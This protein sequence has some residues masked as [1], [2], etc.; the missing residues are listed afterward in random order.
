MASVRAPGPFRTRP[1]RVDVPKDESAKE[2]NT[3]RPCGPFDRH[4]TRQ[5]N[6]KVSPARH[7]L[8]S[9][10]K[11]LI[12]TKPLPSHTAPKSSRAALGA[13]SELPWE[14]SWE[15]LHDPQAPKNRQAARDLL[16]RSQDSCSTIASSPPA[17]EGTEDQALTANWPSVKTLCRTCG[18]PQ[19]SEESISRAPPGL[20]VSR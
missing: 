12:N 16:S 14:W 17:P 6:P 4:L 1:R 2:A 5:G 7:Q 9:W 11:E 3:L 20:G 13:G 19:N 10:S 8:A 15:A 18:L